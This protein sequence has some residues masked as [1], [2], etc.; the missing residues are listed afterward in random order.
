MHAPT[1][2]AIE[3]PR[4]CVVPTGAHAR[5]DGGHPKIRAVRAWGVLALCEG[6]VFAFGA[7]CV[8]VCVCVWVCRMWS[9]RPTF[10][11]TMTCSPRWPEIVNSEAALRRGTPRDPASQ[12]IVNRVFYAKA[13]QLLRDL[14]SG[15]IFNQPTQYILYVFEFQASLAAMCQPGCSLACLRSTS[16]LTSLYPCGRAPLAETGSPP[17]P[18][19]L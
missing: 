1:L 2:A 7:V 13:Q 10:F 19:C 18:H 3:R 9:P 15:S 16:M 12:A 5:R 17:H 4:V 6:P 11:I 14:R 8:C